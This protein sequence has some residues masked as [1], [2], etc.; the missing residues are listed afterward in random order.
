M[1][2]VMPFI[3]AMVVTMTT[4]PLLARM[5]G[6]LGLLDRPGGRKVHSTPIA[7]VVFSLVGFVLE[8]DR[9]YVAVTL[10]V[11]AILIYSLGWGT[12]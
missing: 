7:R 8:K 4:L 9:T 2:G 3:V 6:S 11:L 5:A 1:P 12:L 10:I